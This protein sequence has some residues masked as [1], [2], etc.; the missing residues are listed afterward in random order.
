MYLYSESFQS[1]LSFASSLMLLDDERLMKHLGRLLFIAH[2]LSRVNKGDTGL[3]EATIRFTVCN[4][5]S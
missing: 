5:N 4:C 1:F 2:L 3:L